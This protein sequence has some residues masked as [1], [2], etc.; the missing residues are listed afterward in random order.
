M[1]LSFWFV[2]FF[3]EQAVYLRFS[4]LSNFQPRFYIGS[5]S[6]TVLG[7]EHTR[8]R[9][10]TQVQQNKFVLAEVALRFWNKFDNFWMWSIF[11]LFTDNP[12]FWALEQALI[13]LWQPRLNTPFIDEFFRTHCTASLLF[14]ASVRKFFPL[15]QT[16]LGI[17][18]KASSGDLLQPEVP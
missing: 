10:F 7:R 17:N 8:F 5:T 11:L 12:N 6:S 3:D 16:T 18:T 14:I 15:A 9:K 2:S 13:Q 4:H 1:T